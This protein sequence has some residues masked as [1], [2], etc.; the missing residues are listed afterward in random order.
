MEGL[1]GGGSAT[2]ALICSD[3][4]DAGSGAGESVRDG[5]KRFFKVNASLLEHEEAAEK[6]SLV[7]VW[8]DITERR[9]T[10][11][12]MEKA[13]ARQEFSTDLLTHD[14]TNIFQ[15]LL[16][17]LELV[18]MEPALSTKVTQLVQ[19]ALKQLNRGV[20]MVTQM[21]IF[22]RRENPPES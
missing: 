3:R 19:N 14:L 16:S 7:S 9:Q 20:D 8:R 21:K 5:E 15:G 17:L 12:S 6:G 18:L 22:M 2:G 10:E 4:V 1:G 13:R 11:G